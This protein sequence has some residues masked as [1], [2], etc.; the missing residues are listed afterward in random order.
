MAKAKSLLDAAKALPI[1]TPKWG[2]RKLLTP[3]QLADYE[4][5]LDYMRAGTIG[6][7]RPSAVDSIELVL[8]TYG[9]KLT[10]HTFREHLRGK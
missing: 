10:Q 9:V 3:D 6:I 8:E 4:K 2:F 5:F 1:R 7:D